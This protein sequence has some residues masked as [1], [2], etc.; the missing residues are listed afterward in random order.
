MVTIP[1]AAVGAISAALIAG[2]VSLLGLV[3]SK[4]QKTSEFRQAWIDALRG[5]LT[6]FLTQINAICDA[7]AVK[8]DTHA[9]KVEALGH[10][11]IALNSSNFDILLRLNPKEKQSQ[12]LLDAM[13]SCNLITSDETLLT[14][15]NLRQIEREFIAASQ[16]LLKSEWQRV[17]SGEWAFR[18]AKWL[19]L[20][21]VL[22]SLAAGVLA[23]YHMWG[24]EDRD[25]ERFAAPRSW[26]SVG[27]WSTVH[28]AIGNPSNIQGTE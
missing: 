16:A 22:A 20:G 4:E 8:H 12:T 6:T 15:N 17:K 3:I 21:T 14:A 25:F 10:L 24:L 27:A 26:P 7:I 18:V 13:R 5:D 11:Y 2:I 19:A 28:N 9:K 23:A 1:D